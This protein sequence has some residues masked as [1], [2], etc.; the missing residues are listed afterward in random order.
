[1]AATIEKAGNAEVSTPNDLITAT[2]HDGPTSGDST[3]AQRKD[4]PPE[5]P[6]DIRRRSWVIFSFWAIVLFLGLPIWYKTTTI[7]RANLPLSQM[8]E[9]ADGKVVSFLPQPVMPP[10]RTRLLTLLSHWLG[11]SS[12]LSPEDRAGSG[13]STRTGG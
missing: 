9:W 2:G 11:M 4:A 13:P 12:R 8:L 1:M 7:Y 6:S 10:L 5:K 3:T